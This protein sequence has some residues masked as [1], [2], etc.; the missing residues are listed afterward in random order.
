MLHIIINTVPGYVTWNFLC[1]IAAGGAIWALLIATKTLGGEEDNGRWELL[2]SGQTTA[3]KATI[4]SLWGLY[5]GVVVIFI[6][7]S[8]SV[9]GIGR[10]H[11][12]QFTS[13]SSV[14]FALS[15][16]LGAAEFIAVGALAS[17]L[18]SV[19]SRA[20][21]LSAVI[22]GVF[23][24]TRLVADTTSAHWFLNVSPLGWIERLQPMY[25][26]QP[27]W[28]IPIVGFILSLTFIAIYLSGKRDLGESILADNSSP[29]PRMRLLNSSF[30]AAFRLT[31]ASI[32][33][34]I[35]AVILSSFLYG[36][37]AKNAA[38]SLLGNQSSTTVRT[39]RQLTQANNTRSTAEFMGLTF[40]II[41]VL[42]MFYAASAIGQLR[43]DEAEGYLDNFL[44]RSISRIRWIFGRIFLILIFIIS[45]GILSGLSGW[46]GQASQHGG[47]S[48]SSILGAGA[49]AMVPA[50]LVLGIG[51]FAVGVAPRQASI[52][53]YAVIGWS[54]L[55]VML[56]SGL[57][58]NHWL[59]DTSILHQVTFAPAISPNW[60]VNGVIIAISVILVVFGTI[61]FN[62]R[63]LQGN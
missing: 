21:G 15:L 25:A 59:L 24:M 60:K 42:V 19:R 12:V 52:F 2:L 28:L 33:G 9:I 11:D 20:A 47:V 40:F 34:W 53:T 23:Y 6:L 35:S 3:R 37:L 18:M 16:I 56:S 39:L 61:R 54:F 29:K 17:Q 43:G 62:K 36:L 22:F 50:V 63:D 10:L 57:N 4:N 27:I 7:L 46:L 38:Q 51:I 31:R 55:M 32:I 1:L 44:V 26:S 30:G 49:N 13:S 45:A 8:V 14:F 41:M 5:S 48:L 58:L